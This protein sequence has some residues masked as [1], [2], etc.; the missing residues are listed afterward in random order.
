M[1]AHG[2]VFCG[3]SLTAFNVRT[4]QSATNYAEDRQNLMAMG[5]CRLGRGPRLQGLDLQTPQCLLC[6][7]FQGVLFLTNRSQ[8][9]PALR[10]IGLL[11]WRQ[12]AQLPPRRHKTPSSHPRIRTIDFRVW[13]MAILGNTADVNYVPE[14]TFAFISHRL[15]CM[16]V[17]F[18]IF[19]AT[20]LLYFRS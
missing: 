8:L 9:P 15:I 7:H 11:S 6:G 1:L 19:K 2:Y 18:Q 10:V 12:I 5:D 3:H 14:L 17:K 4:S 16:L 20:M 13:K